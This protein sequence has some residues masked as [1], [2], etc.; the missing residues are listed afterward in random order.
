[1]KENTDNQNINITDM[2][3]KASL[4]GDEDGNLKLDIN[5]GMLLKSNSK[6]FLKGKIKTLGFDVPV[7]IKIE[8][9]IE[10]QIKH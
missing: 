3:A 1:M 5:T 7:S 10:G 8:K 4:K 9:S 2:Q 6:V